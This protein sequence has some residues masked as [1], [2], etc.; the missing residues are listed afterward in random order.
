MSSTGAKKT[1][2]PITRPEFHEKAQ[3]ITI[4]VDGTNFK[5]FPEDFNTGSVGYK[6]NTKLPIKVGDKTV[7]FQVGLNITAVGSKELP[8]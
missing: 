2:C 3:T 1:V 5:L 6:L 4:T 7:Q 8:K